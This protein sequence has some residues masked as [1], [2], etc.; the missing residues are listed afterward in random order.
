MS[1]IFLSFLGTNDYVECSYSFKRQTARNVRFVQEALV[2]LFCQD[3]EPEDRICIL[4]TDKARKKNWENSTGRNGEFTKGLAERI[5]QTKASV[6]CVSIPEGHS[7]KEIWEIF[8]TLYNNLNSE[9]R[10]ILDITHGFRFLPMLTMIL[11]NYARFLKKITI[12]AIY[13]GAFEVLGPAYKVKDMPVSERLAPIFDL[14][15]FDALQL[16]SHG[17]E[18]FVS[19]GNPDK[20]SS[21]ARESVIQRL[22]ES[23]GKDIEA[24]RLQGLAENLTIL[25]RQILTN[26]GSD[27]VSGKTASYVRGYLDE[28]VAVNNPG[29]QPL[30]DEIKKKIERFQDDT[31]YNG[32]V[33]VQWCLDHN[34]IQQG[35]TIL[36]ETILTLLLHLLGEDWGNKNL[37]EAISSAFII[38][39]RNIPEKE[40]NVTCTKHSELI[41]KVCA[42]PVFPKAVKAY[43]ALSKCRNDI[44]HAGFTQ[45]H[46]K[47]EKFKP[48]LEK[49]FL[50]LQGMFTRV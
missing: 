14:T 6:Q 27:I 37:R 35:L 39:S 40:W 33:A 17:A 25:S 36:Q 12:E 16:W 10:V 22:K 4:L 13:Y 32:F 26:R 23:K 41:R 19:F 38:V 18:N 21:L 2:G 3:F 44:N 49:Q 30:L 20:I 47:A 11:L 7:E 31:P 45:D 48:E 24:K 34:L 1:R 42:L 43:D 46:R 8:N 9:D 28:L 29:L 15:S 5:V 50:V